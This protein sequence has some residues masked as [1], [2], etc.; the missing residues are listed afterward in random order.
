MEQLEQRTKPKNKQVTIKETPEIINQPN[1]DV[2]N[3]LKSPN[4]INLNEDNK[5]LKE[6]TTIKQ[7]KKPKH[8]KESNEQDEHK[9]DQKDKETDIKPKNQQN[10][11]LT[12]KPKTDIIDSLTKFNFVPNINT[13]I[14]I[15]VIIVC[16]IIFTIMNKE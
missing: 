4:L 12:D 13:L 9:A 14:F 5:E 3:P 1:E 10:K 11:K 6:K 8:K 2:L 15:I 16:F 7:L